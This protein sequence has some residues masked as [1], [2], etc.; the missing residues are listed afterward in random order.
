M[1]EIT[2]PKLKFLKI[3]S[4]R[5]NRKQHNTAVAL[6]ASALAKI[7]VEVNYDHVDSLI[8]KNRDIPLE[9]FTKTK[10]RK[11]DLAFILPDDTLVHVHVD[12][13]QRAPSLIVLDIINKEQAK[14]KEQ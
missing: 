13:F 11:A 4:D 10:T 3:N 1:A 9:S 2:D 5:A 8:P 14:K 12:V 6:L 7:G